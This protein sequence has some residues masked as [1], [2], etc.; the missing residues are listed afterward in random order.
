[1]LRIKNKKIVRNDFF[2]IMRS[3]KGF[4]NAL[5]R[6]TIALINFF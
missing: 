6:L 2:I 4:E 5:Y 1:L 3:F